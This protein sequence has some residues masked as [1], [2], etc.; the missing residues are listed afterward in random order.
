[1]ND[2]VLDFIEDHRALIFAGVGLIV[3]IAVVLGIRGVNAKKKAQ[4]ELKAQKEAEI[5]AEL[6]KSSGLEQDEPEVVQPVNEYQASLG[7]EAERNRD[8]RV[9]VKDP[10]PYVPPEPV[11][12]AKAKYPPTVN[13]F[14]NTAVPDKNVDGSSCKAYMNGVTLSDFGVLWGED[15]TDDDFTGNSRYLVGV[16]QNPQDFN[17]G[18][19]QSVG[20]LIENLG[21]M[22]AN[23]CIKF[24]NLHVIGSLSSSHVAL[25]C[26]YDWYSAFGLKD[27]LVVFEDHSGT[28][29][30]EDFK[31]GD[32]FSATAYV[33]NIKIV[34]ANGQKVVVV[35]YEVFS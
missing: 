11:T 18:D 4:A 26:S 5:L 23:D 8:E 24:T 34:E 10:D 17:R 22:Q 20:W 16:E 7:L 28:L 25:L 35:S 15:L 6:E 32:I 1:M 14:D 21:T 30:V 13:I 12:E 27:T 9:D 31:E 19:L 33:H 3:L 2:K 29:K